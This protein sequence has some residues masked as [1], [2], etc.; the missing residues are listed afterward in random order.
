MKTVRVKMPTEVGISD[1]IYCIGMKFYNFETT[2]LFMVAA[3]PRDLGSNE[4]RII[5]P[6]MRTGAYHTNSV[7]VASTQKI[8]YQNMVDLFGSL[9]FDSFTMI[10]MIFD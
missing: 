10:D 9:D 2:Q 3:V 5:L 8:T 4:N 7:V 6:N 1:M